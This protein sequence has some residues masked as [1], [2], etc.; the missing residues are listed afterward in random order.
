MKTL[1]QTLI[2]FSFI[3]LF[4]A[5]ET[6]EIGE[7]DCITCQT[8]QTE[9]CFTEGYAYY[10]VTAVD[11]S[12]VAG[13]LIGSWEDTK[14]I[15]TSQ[16]N[17]S[18]PITDCYTC[19]NTNTEYCYTTTDDFYTVTVGNDI[20]TQESL[21]GNTWAELKT[22]FIEDCG[23]SSQEEYDFIGQWKLTNLT[24]ASTNVVSFNDD[25]IP[26]I[27]SITNQTY[28]S[29]DAYLNFND[30][31]NTYT[32]NGAIMINSITTV[33]GVETNNFD[34]SSDSTGSGVW[35][36]NNDQMELTDDTTSTTT[37]STIIEYTNEVFKIKYTTH[38][39][40]DNAAGNSTTD[41]T[42]IQTYT[43]Q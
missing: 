26:Q 32:S 12:E 30:N 37:T 43:K 14:L 19:S 7:T 23:G 20:P 16:C 38:S 21:N 3:F 35:L 34:Y 17:N 1:K 33:D 29:G 41:L 5:C 24:L 18:N 2:I 10:V 28:L 39:S 36:I 31:P 4:T 6:N 15:L 22:D 11:G 8:T 42:S 27:T 40:V 25:T 13:N 9:Y